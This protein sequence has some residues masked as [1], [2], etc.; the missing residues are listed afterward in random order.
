[1][2]SLPAEIQ[3]AIVGTQDGNLN[4]ANDVPVPKLEDDMILVR[5]SVMGLNPVDTKMTGNLCTT[6][7]V[8]GM[9]FAGVVLAI[10]SK[11]KTAGDITVGDRVCGAVQGMHALTPTVGAFAQ[12]VGASDVVTLKI[13]PSMT[14]EEAASLG[15]GVGTIG[16]ALYKSLEIPGTPLKPAEVPRFV[17]VY[18]G[19]TA[20]GTLALQ[21]LKLSGMRPITTCSPKNFDLAKSYGAEAVFDYRSAS[22]IEDIKTYTK[23]SLKYVLDCVS[24]P[25]T[26]RFC[27]KAIGRAGGKYT[28]LEPFAQ[29]LHTRPTVQPDWVLGPTLLG[30]PIGWSPPFER[31]AN[32][33]MREF[34]LDWFK[35]VQNLLDEGKLR[36]HPVRIL[37][38]GFEAALE[39]LDLLREK[40]VSGQK[41]VC[42]I[43]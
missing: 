36:T 31:Q 12:V 28:A 33:K 17:L 30:K 13:P 9:D 18:G 4:I 3:T 15:S 8:A 29:S 25:E 16:L 34:T 14:L 43:S 39:G 21:I 22:A 23:N 1:M 35:T 2:G 24:E 40:K 32:P 37:T 26:M 5:N 20:T 7:A 38:G 11:V 42:R 10:G 6:G 41:L 19:S 27:Y